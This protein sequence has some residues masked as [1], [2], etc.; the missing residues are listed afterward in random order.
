MKQYLQ[1][2]FLLLGL[3]SFQTAVAGT[4][5]ATSDRLPLA[6]LALHRETGRTIYLGA[7][8]A[9]LPL[10]GP[11]DILATGVDQVMEFIIV[12]RRTSM[13]SLLG[14]VLLQ[15]EVATGAAPAITTVAFFQAII[16]RMQGSLYANDHFA[17]RHTDSTEIVALL[18]GQELA[19]SDV[20]GTFGYLLAGWVAERGAT[21]AFRNS[22]LAGAVDPAL[23]ER[24]RA[25]EPDAERLASV[26]AWM[27]QPEAEPEAAPATRQSLSA[28]SQPKIALAPPAAG[29][30]A[31]SATRVARTI[32]TPV[33]TLT[34]PS[35]S[36]T[37][38]AAAPMVDTKPTVI[39]AAA[40]PANG[41][42]T[43]STSEYSRHLASF[44]T[45]VYRM[46]NAEIRYPRRAIRRNIEG[47]LEL[48]LVFGPRGD[49]LDVSVA[50]SSGHN[51]LDNSALEA[52]RSAFV[53][54]LA[55]P[56]DETVIAEY[57]SDNNRL[58]I[59]VP[60]NFILSE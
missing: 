19:R 49:L 31:A 47:E 39:T 41:V 53:R 7:L 25:L 51:M 24:Y 32:A 38:K 28:A 18:N 10:A 44:N 37:I 59:P 11:Q 30:A 27:Q 3:L 52:A 5:P 29:P 48:D 1:R 40:S 4:V 35:G 34:A 22:L 6:G 23:R 58:V 26:A 60:V 46:V 16:V 57:A 17:L 8:H 55:L 13:R 42:E 50:H 14:G 36:P 54:P 9:R 12:A 2:W 33:A 15:A 56:L 43:L 21:T 20:A 45:M